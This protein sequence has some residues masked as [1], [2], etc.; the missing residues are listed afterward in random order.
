MANP[1][2]SDVQAI[3]A[4]MAKVT[5]KGH[6][7]YLKQLVFTSQNDFPG[8]ADEKL[9]IGHMRDS[10]DPLFCY[11]NRRKKQLE[12]YYQSEKDSAPP[13]ATKSVLITNIEMYKLVEPFARLVQPG[14]S[15]FSRNKLIR[16]MINACFAMRG[17]TAD[18]PVDIHVQFKRGLKAAIRA[19]ECR[20][21]A[22]G[23]NSSSH[24][25]ATETPFEKRGISRV[26]KLASSNKPSATP[27][28][29]G[30]A[31]NQNS[32]PSS[33]MFGVLVPQSSRAQRSQRRSQLRNNDSSR[34]SQ[35]TLSAGQASKSPSAAEY[36]NEQTSDG[37]I[38]LG[39]PEAANAQIERELGGANGPNNSMC[40][41]TPGSVLENNPPSLGAQ[42]NRDGTD[43]CEGR[44]SSSTGINEDIIQFYINELLK[45]NQSQQQLE[46]VQHA[47]DLSEKKLKE[48][49]EITKQMEQQRSTAAEVTAGHKRKMEET[50][51]D[52]E[53]RAKRLKDVKAAMTGEEGF[54]LAMRL[55]RD[56]HKPI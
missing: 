35:S 38:R 39:S 40:I 17:L 26:G 51:S 24:E 55:V 10:L 22:R 8:A 4:I 12:A 11:R 32:G 36:E 16:Y 2:A 20:R 13:N 30:V 54:E 23:S 45:Q 34:L 1:L 19:I 5:G 42:H 28:A 49:E 50:K 41:S 25:E 9:L 29:S 15:H 6:F 44:D 27:R 33:G 43:Q 48:L 46:E 18:D 7:P 3:T 56:G 52:I 37:H 21:D 31:G 47:T 53:M 14:Q